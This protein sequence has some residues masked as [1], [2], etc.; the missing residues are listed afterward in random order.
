MGDTRGHAAD[1]DASL[2]A[3]CWQVRWTRTQ[4]AWSQGA[5]VVTAN[6]VRIQ[7]RTVCTV[8]NVPL[9]PFFGYE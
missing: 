3:F 9:G 1:L 8:E 4:K 2:G 6:D 7:Y 5:L